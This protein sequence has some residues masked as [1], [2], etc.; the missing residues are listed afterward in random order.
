MPAPKE[1]NYKFIGG[2]FIAEDPLFV[3][4]PGFSVTGRAGMTEIR[5]RFWLLELLAAMVPILWLFMWAIRRHRQRHGPPGC[6]RTC[7]YDLQ[8]IPNRCP[9]CGAPSGR[10]IVRGNRLDVIYT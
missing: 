2:S 1:R 10:V 8:G 7:G 4:T 3:G 6:C 9:E 5:L